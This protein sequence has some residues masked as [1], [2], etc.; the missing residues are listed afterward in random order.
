M[1]SDE[2]LAATA[3]AKPIGE[4]LL[5]RLK[6]AGKV[7]ERTGRL[8][9]ASHRPAVADEDQRALSKVERLFLD[10]AFNPPA[11]EEVAA[12]AGI[13]LPRAAKAVRLLTEERK[14]VAVAPGLL[15]HADA[16]ARA[17]QILTDYIRKEGQMES[18]KFK[19]L[20]D[21]SRKFAIPLLDHFDRIGV[22]RASGHTRFLRPPKP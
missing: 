22:T 8:A 20:L 15:F 21:T 12:A 4:G 6:A 14:L 16:I 13:P 2:L 9:L 10:Q 11:P 17:R 18:V 7:A 3:L 19:Y 5:A 1:T